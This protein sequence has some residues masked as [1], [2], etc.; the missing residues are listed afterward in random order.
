MKNI[1]SGILAIVA[2]FLAVAAQAQGVLGIA[3]QPNVFNY[4]YIEVDYIS[5]DDFST[6]GNLDP[7][8]DGFRVKGS[9]DIDPNLALIGSIGYAGENNVDLTMISFG[10]AYHQKLEKTQLKQSDFSIYAEIE[11]WDVEIDNAKGDKDD[12]GLHAGAA[13]RIKVVE[14]F[15]IFGDLSVRTTMDND[16]AAEVGGRYAFTPRLHGVASIEISDADTLAAG[17]RYY[18]D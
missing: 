3:P 6:R 5:I 2:G 8:L 11:R 7:D 4:D 10:T 18:L 15:E 12:I 13:F 9:M 1:Y 16:M 14:K 17:L